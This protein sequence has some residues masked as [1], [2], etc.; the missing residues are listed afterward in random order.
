[1]EQFM[2]ST[3]RSTWLCIY[4]NADII[5]SHGMALNIALSSCYSLRCP[6]SATHFRSTE[7][8]QLFQVSL[9]C[10]VPNKN[11]FSFSTLQFIVSLFTEHILRCSISNKTVSA[12]PPLPSMVRLLYSNAS[13]T[14]TFLH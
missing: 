9:H 5:T 6:I 7:Q 14:K 2:S 13:L 12:F 4:N 10:S 11:S 8:F 1:M 3:T